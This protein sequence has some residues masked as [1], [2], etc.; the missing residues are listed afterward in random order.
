MNFRDI[1]RKWQKVWKEDELYKTD[2]SDHKKK[3]YNLVMFPYPSG[4]KLHVGHC[5]NNG[6]AD[7]HGR[8]MR[9]LGYNVFEPMGFDSFG[10]PAENYAIKTGVH[11]KISTEKNIEYMTQQLSEMGAM[12][13]WSH[14]LSTSSQEYY[15]WT[16]W[17]FL[18]LHK[19]GLAYQKEARVN[20]CP[21][22]KTVLANEQVHSGGC[23]RCGTTV[24][25]KNLKQWFLSIT[26]YADRLLDFEGLEWPEK[27]IKMQQNWI[28]KSVGTEMTMK[29]DNSELSFDV[30]TTRIDTVY[31]MTYCVIAPEHELATRITT[32]ENL[33]TVNEYIEVVKKKSDLERTDLNKDK[34]GVFTGSYAINPFNEKKVPIYIADYVLM[35]Y[36]TGALMAVPAHDERDFEF[37]KKYNLEIIEVISP[38]GEKETC[39]PESPF[40]F[41]GVLTNSSE[42]NQ[43]DSDTA[44]QKM[45]TWLL[46]NQLGFPTTKFKLKDWLIS[47]Q[48]Y[49][50]CPI[51]IVH[52]DDCGAVPLPESE[53]PVILPNDA[54][55]SPHGD[56]PLL[57][58]DKF[59]NVK[60]PKCNKLATRETDTMDTFIDSSWYFL[61]FLDANNDKVAF[62]KELVRKWMPVDMY[63]GGPE[64]ACMHLL[65]AR[66]INMVLYDNKYIDNKEP[67][68][69]LIHQGMITKDG[70]KMSKSKGNVVSPDQFVSKYGSDVFRMYLM[71][72]GPYTDGADWNDNG[73]LGIDRFMK[74]T[75]AKLSISECSPKHT[76]KD[77]ALL[78]Q[79]IKRVTEGLDKF[80]FNTAIA[81]LME[82]NKNYSNPLLT[83]EAKKIYITLLAPFAPHIAEELWEKTGMHNT[84]FNES[85]P[86]Y[87]SEKLVG[88]SI[89]LP[90]QINGKVRGFYEAEKD[91]EQKEIIEAVKEIPNIN[92][93]LEN[94]DIIKIIY[95]KGKIINIIIK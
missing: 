11:P 25:Q 23:E 79:T 63:I 18:Q 8:Y 93:Y 56:S 86:K 80:H 16:Q 9:M 74:R 21:K 60:C 22:D 88:G 57:T 72:L 41:K 43:L 39:F 35:E 52:C 27:T 82:F 81:A 42:Y 73:I 10:L 12:Y 65:Y 2:L 24:I 49:W 31:G 77:E 69:R 26:D 75:F 20:Y 6:P 37:A 62:D 66:F 64:H 78:H 91:A 50:G 45:N 94:K 89:K 61:R 14:S 68:K 95:V 36:G 33:E 92:K 59:K 71:F 15:K 87:N 7:T 29:I 46:D 17:L 84:V 44:K 1:D 67:F 48:R 3:Y 4:D 85:W 90:I 76:E 40:T 55:F 47:R 70:A 30:Y 28:G 54:K 32:T 34:R 51:P 58:H 83:Y 53:L 13:D 19:K 5:Y 38:A